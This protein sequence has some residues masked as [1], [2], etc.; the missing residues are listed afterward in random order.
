MQ[1]RVKRDGELMIFNY[2]PG[3]DF[4]NEMIRE[5]R[6]VILDSDLNVI[7]RGFDKFG[8]YSEAYAADIKWVSAVVQ[9]KLDGSIVKLYWYGGKWNWATNSVIYAKDAPTQGRYKNFQELIDEADNLP[10]IDI[11]EKEYTYIFELVSPYNQIVVRYPKTHLY[12][13]GTREKFGEEI[14]VD[15]GVEKP[16]TYELATL[17]KCIE[18]VKNLNGEEVTNEGFV[19]CDKYFNRVKI[20]TPEYFELHRERFMTLTGKNAIDL[21][22]SK[23]YDELIKDFPQFDVEF[24]WYLYQWK[25]FLRH[26]REMEVYAA[27]LYDEYEQ[28]RKLVASEIEGNPYAHF[29]FM[30]INGRPVKEEDL[31]WKDIK[32]F[33]GEK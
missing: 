10:N 12:H 5:C 9:E 24:A 8:N 18:A 13:I 6:G 19:V 16:K 7:C 14:L 22:R 28:N 33:I 2:L 27:N 26:K 23:P 15:I 11:L 3:A 31:K 4:S 32:N 17:E 25:D 21:I 29:G 20:K 30:A 1:V